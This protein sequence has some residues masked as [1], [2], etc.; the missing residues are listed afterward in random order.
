MPDAIHSEDSA[1]G[2]L[3]PWILLGLAVL[4]LG[5]DQGYRLFL[6]SR[7]QSEMSR[8]RKEGFPVTEA[9]LQ[10]WLPVLADEENG[11]V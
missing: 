6:Q 4:V 10:H 9:E 7:V 3:W 5:A 8:F 11:A 2:R 1:R